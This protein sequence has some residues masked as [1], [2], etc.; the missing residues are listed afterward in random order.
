VG[1]SIPVSNLSPRLVRLLEF[2]LRSA[3]PVKVDVLSRALH[4][5]R[6]TVFRELETIETALAASQT[7]LLSVSGKGIAFSGDSE[8][9]Q[10]LL[11]FLPDYSSQPVS[12]R[13]RLLC[14][15]IKLIANAGETKKLFYYA[16]ALA[17]SESTISHDLDELEAWLSGRGITLIRK[18]GFGVYCDGTE[19]ALR[20][21]LV[22][23]FML[24][25][26][27]GGKSYPGVFDFPGEDIETGVREILRRKAG[28]IDWM[29]SESLCLIAVYL[30]V[31]IERAY[32][33]KIITEA[34]SPAGHFQTALA[35]EIAAEIEKEFS[36]AL[37]ETER[38]SLAGWIQSCRSK[39]ESPLEPDQQSLMQNLTMRMIDRFDPPSAAVLKTNEQL[40]GLLSRHLESAL[41]RI[42]DGK[43]LPNPLEAELIRNYPE[44][45]EKTRGAA[46]VLEEHLGIEVSSNE[47]SF[48]QI[49]FLAALA[50]LG[51]RNIKRRIL[52]AG[53]VCVS[54][55][56]TSY[57]LAYQIR[58]RFKG[59]LEVEV[60]G[61][62]DSASWAN[63]DFLI[64]T[65]PLEKAQQPLVLVQTILGEED[66]KKIQELIQ[67][68]AFTGRKTEQA[69]PSRFLEKKLDS[70]IALFMQSRKLLDTFSVESIKAD[71]SFDELVRFAATRFSPENPE[72]VCHALVAREAVNTQ[73][74]PEL[75]IALLHTRN[76]RDTSPVFA[77]IIPRG[78]IF[79]HDYFKRAKSCVLMLLPE[80]AP[81]EMTDLMGGI[82]SALI[83]MP[84]FL[85]AIRAGTREIIQ[86]VLEREISEI[87]VCYNRGT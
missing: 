84:D 41:P 53:I 83:D 22:S 49:H 21:A 6:R 43:Y 26:D 82:S 52:R 4:I 46:Q 72:V 79:T 86:A 1:N 62:D 64:S 85:E 73:V 32:D 35:E 16:N 10:K 58:K 61:Y 60:S 76:A 29:T 36:L 63:T 25:G 19:E 33:G 48:I 66:F 71:C 69:G 55:I 34:Q 87:L 45:Y 15:L 2:L 40:T 80:N 12:K 14:L 77:V 31:T 27:T 57:M 54:G 24:D 3:E 18:S 70:M 67:T 42:K 28:V 38:Q 5:S 8:A 56:G 30:M 20:T 81:R 23:R 47:V 13:E 37:P 7:S 59:E 68:F 11:E 17:A 51:D 44:V 9:R 78:G 75:E 50:F 65:I 74:V 39:Q